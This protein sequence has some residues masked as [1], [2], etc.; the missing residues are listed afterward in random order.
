MTEKSGKGKT[1][2]TT[3]TVTTVTTLGDLVD[4][5]SRPKERRNS[6]AKRTH[7]TA[8]KKTTSAKTGRLEERI[9]EN[10][11]ALQSVHADL[12][13][14][15]DSLSKEI[16]GLLKLF[17]TAAQSFA[18]SSP[19]GEFTK[20]KEF[21]EKIDKLLDQNKTI[22]RGLT[23]MEEKLRAKVYGTPVSETA[24][25]QFQPSLGS[26]RPLPRF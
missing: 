12:A 11:I 4:N 14:K 5:A 20:D 19:V 13:E 24:E 23:L 22:A 9:I 3:K 10:L 8:A 25:E 26:N 15:F 2:K 18:R 21:L 7:R 1:K 17:E 6:Y 16:S